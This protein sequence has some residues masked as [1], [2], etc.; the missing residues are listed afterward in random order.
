[1]STQSTRHLL[2]DGILLALQMDLLAFMDSVF[3]K[4]EGLAEK[5]Q[6]LNSSPSSWDLSI[7]R[8]PLMADTEYQITQIVKEEE[9]GIIFHL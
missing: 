4:K 1:M 7:G 5:F 3:P 8:C 6:V 2:S 9:T